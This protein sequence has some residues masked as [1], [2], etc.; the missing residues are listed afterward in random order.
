M[1]LRRETSIDIQ[2]KTKDD[3]SADTLEY[4]FNEDPK[5]ARS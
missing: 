2:I 1:L 4:C 5:F 3:L